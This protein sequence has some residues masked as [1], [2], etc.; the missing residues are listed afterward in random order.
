MYFVS[1]N[2]TIHINF[3]NFERFHDITTIINNNI[4]SLTISTHAQ[5]KAFLK[6]TVLAAI[7][8]DAVDDAVLVAWTLIVD[9]RRLR[10][11]EEA[12]AALAR[13]DA[14]VH[15]TAL[16]AAYLAGYDLD[17]CCNRNNKINIMLYNTHSRRFNRLRI[18]LEI[19][20]ELRLAW[21]NVL[22]VNVNNTS[23]NMG[24]VIFHRLVCHLMAFRLECF[25]SCVFNCT[26][27]LM[28]LVLLL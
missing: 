15:A 14:V 10:A 20:V 26:R 27:K 13:D 25:S 1:R 19:A 8:I 4:T 16:V 11:P 17:L 28:L 7:A 9:H 3:Q 22:N 6:A 18:K 24:T 12:L 5:S 21:I 2:C 23:P